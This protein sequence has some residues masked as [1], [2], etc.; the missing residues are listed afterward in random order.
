MKTRDIV[1][2]AGKNLRQAK[3]RTLLTSLA[4]SVGAFTVTVALAAGAGGQAYTEK[5]VQNNG[6]MNSLSVYAKID[7]NS[8][9]PKEYSTNGSGGFAPDV[10]TTRDIETIKAIE[11][12]S[13]VIPAY[14]VNALYMTRGGDAEKYETTLRIKDDRTAMPLLAG[15]LENNQVPEG[16]VVV[17]EDYL[18][19]LG[20]ETAE[21][22]IGKSLTVRI[23]K[24]GEIDAAEHKDETFTI[25][26]VDKKS[27]TV[28]R[29]SAALRIS[30]A[31]GQAI[32]Q[33]QV[34]DLSQSD[35][36]SGLTVRVE[37]GADVQEVQRAIEAAGYTVFSLQ[38]QEQ[39][40]FQFINIV[41]WG[42]VG[43]GFIAI[44]ASVFGIINTQYISVLERT[45]QIGLMKALGAHR[46]DIGRL[47]RYEAAWVGFLGGA[48][49]TALAVLTGF[50]NPLIASSLELEEGTN[51]LLFSPLVSVALILALMLIAVL[52]GYF[53]SR[54]AAKLDPI[55]ALRTE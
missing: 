7:E 2:R 22:A 1:R 33:Y 16:G 20:F 32:Y 14:S 47:F 9:A 51:L 37:P 19:V 4:I 36:Y 15:S 3:V 18:G 30:V 21:E 45:Q 39:S 46:R 34:G 11:N 28:L 10:I 35:E 55:E 52:A 27:M 6:D 50:L 29:Y 12:V 23:K 54:K 41:Q 42:M 38:D 17:P 8:E 13:E 24:A 44:L 40:L 48:I 49:G 26:A 5:M 25:V 53:P 43:F 31:D